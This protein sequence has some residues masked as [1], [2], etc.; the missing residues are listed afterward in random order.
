V[1]ADYEPLA[2]DQATDYCWA[3]IAVHE[4]EIGDPP[5]IV[6]QHPARTCHVGIASDMG[7]RIV[8]SE[9][10][11]S[12]QLERVPTKALKNSRRGPTAS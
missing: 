11:R 9:D 12:E 1:F 5:H 2:L 8:H 7:R 6:L 10:D 3:R 4:D